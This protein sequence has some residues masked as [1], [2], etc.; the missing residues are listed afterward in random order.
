MRTSCIEALPILEIQKK[1][2][3]R[4][5]MSLT[6]EKGNLQ[7]HNHMMKYNTEVNIS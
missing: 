4:N 5:Q 2:N 6:G 7:W 1:R 3:E